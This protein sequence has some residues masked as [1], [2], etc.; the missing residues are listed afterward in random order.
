MKNDF[1]VVIAGARCAGAAAALLLAR[2]GARVLV[3]DRGTYGTD[4]LSTHALMRGAVVQLNRWG[5]LPTIVSAGTPAVASATFAYRSH[6]TAVPIGPKYG[7]QALYAPRRT[8]LDRALVDAARSA[9]AEFAYRTTVDGVLHDTAG[10]VVGITA[11][12]DRGVHRLRAGMVIGADGR[13]SAVAAAVGAC[14]IQRGA[15]AAGTL[16]S[17]WRGIRGSGYEWH[18][19]DRLNLGIIP[20]NDGLTCV[21]A[22]VPSEG[23]RAAINGDAAAAYRRLIGTASA[24]VSARILAGRQVEM[25][26]G[27]AGHVGIVRKSV[28]PGWA[29]VGDA[30]Y[31]KDPITAHGITDALRDAE[32]LARAI[33]RGGEPALAEYEATR[34]DLSRDLFEV[35]DAIASFA[36]TD[37]ALVGLH[38]GLS[39]AMAHEVRAIVALG[40]T[41]A[42]PALAS[43]ACCSSR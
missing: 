10:R 8:V 15:H 9:G 5:I 35:T 36:W 16:Y 3:F 12:N 37:E 26:R 23:F 2:A 31:F 11:S 6:E 18:Y 43:E 17:Y 20:T 4:T 19:Q 14:D 13:R 42:P 25:V 30:G 33:L 28:G 21:F 39:D 7:V 41:P 34:D 29:L 38:R 40:D 27:F 1:D 32:L 24:S 22:S